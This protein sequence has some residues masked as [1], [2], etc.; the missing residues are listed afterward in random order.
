MSYYQPP[1]API[2]LESGSQRAQ[3]AQV[4]VLSKLEE[5]IRSAIRAL[6]AIED[7]ERAEA[8][9]T[10]SRAHE[11]ALHLLFRS[12]LR[13]TDSSVFQT[14]TQLEGLLRKITT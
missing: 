9:S 10:A 2:S 11:R 3:L 12:D 7:S 8:V 4:E 6:E 13:I 14:L 5:G 1:P